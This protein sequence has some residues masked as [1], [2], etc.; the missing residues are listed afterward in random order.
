MFP[1]TSMA[2]LVALE[3]ERG[4]RRTVVQA[5]AA[6]GRACSAAAKTMNRA[7]AEGESRL[8]PGGR[9]GRAALAASLVRALARK[10]RRYR[11]PSEAV[12]VESRPVDRA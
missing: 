7:T 10:A 12:N 11:F 8:Q 1:W 9:F 3:S 6:G 2:T 5:A 4:S